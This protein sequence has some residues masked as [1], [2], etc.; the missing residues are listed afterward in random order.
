MIHHFS[1]QLDFQQQK[2]NL[3]ARRKHLR[4]RKKKKLSTIQLLAEHKPRDVS[5]DDG[6]SQKAPS[7]NAGAALIFLGYALRAA[8]L[9]VWGPSRAAASLP[10]HSNY[11][12]EI[13]R[14]PTVTHSEE[15]GDQ[16]L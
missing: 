12:D 6:A 1:P 15:G 9:L 3:F 13:P 2:F 16:G 8:Q 4:W 11:P 7:L 5:S 14:A 10:L